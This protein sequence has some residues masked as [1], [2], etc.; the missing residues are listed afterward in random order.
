MTATTTTAAATAVDFANWRKVAKTMT[1]FCLEYAIKDCREAAE[2]MKG[3]NPVK[4]GYYE[5]QAF[6]YADELRA[7]QMKRR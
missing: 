5:D 4:E 1:D 2:A 6:T 3:W 7:R